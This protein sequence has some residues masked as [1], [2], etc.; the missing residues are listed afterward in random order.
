[1]YPNTVSI[2]KGAQLKHSQ[3]AKVRAAIGAFLC[4]A[5]KR[6]PAAASKHPNTVQFGEAMATTLAD[7]FVD[8][9]PWTILELPAH[10][11]PEPPEAPSLSSFQ[12]PA[13]CSNGSGLLPRPQDEHPVHSGM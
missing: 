1:M 9:P 4:Q 12:G 10:R 11:I 3:I 7:D 6:Q 8:P 5:S 2:P 13:F